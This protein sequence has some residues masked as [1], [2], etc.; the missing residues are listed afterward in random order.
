MNKNPFRSI[1][2]VY[3]TGK[4]YEIDCTTEEP[5]YRH[6][7]TGYETVVESNRPVEVINEEQIGVAALSPEAITAIT[8]V[9]SDII[10]NYYRSMDINFLMKNSMVSIGTPVYRA[11]NKD[12]HGKAYNELFGYIGQVIER[13]PDKPLII[14]TASKNRKLRSPVGGRVCGWD[15]VEGLADILANPYDNP[16]ETIKKGQAN[17]LRCLAI[18]HL[19]HEYPGK[20]VQVNKVP[21]GISYEADQIEEFD[22]N[23]EGLPPLPLILPGSRDLYLDKKGQLVLI[24][25]AANVKGTPK[26]DLSLT[27]DGK[28]VFWVSFKHGEYIEEVKRPGEIPFQQWGSHMGIYKQDEF[29]P[30]LDKYLTAVITELGNHYTREQVNQLAPQISNTSDG[31]LEDVLLKTYNDHFNKITQSGALDNSSSLNKQEVDHIHVFPSGTPD[32]ISK[33][34]DNDKKP[35]GDRLEIL[36][37][38][39]IYGDSYSPSSKKMGKNNVNILLQAPESAKFEVV[40]GTPDDPDEIWAVEMKMVKEA[41]VIKNPDLPNAIPYLPCLYTRYTYASPIIFTNTKTKRREAIVGGRVLLYPQG[42]V[43]DSATIVDIS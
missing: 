24:N 1:G 33:L 15:G 39:A 34:F 6:I 10:L 12:L 13:Y 27:L 17:L 41:H 7:S 42:K 32:I 25:G 19:I 5:V 14:T 38:K 35:M 9:D 3:V 16:I 21:A 23:L 28:E 40:K 26:A 18:V 29:K 22:K 30:L 31:T 20:I 8:G 4:T 43:N 2:D 11:V 37:L 36:A